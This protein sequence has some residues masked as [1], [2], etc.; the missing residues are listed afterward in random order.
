MRNTKINQEIIKLNKY[1]LG[2]VY[3]PISDNV[4]DL[5]N[6]I[7]KQPRDN[8]KRILLKICLLN[9]LMH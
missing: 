1:Q 8:D 9:N 3:Y 4:I 2:F 6:F 7:I 5:F